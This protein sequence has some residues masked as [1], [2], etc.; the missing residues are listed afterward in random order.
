MTGGTGRHDAGHSQAYDH[1]PSCSLRRQDELRLTHSERPMLAQCNA[2]QL[3]FAGVERRRVVAA[4]D[5][6]MVSS[7]AAAPMSALRI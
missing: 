7:D 3:E 5:G 4:F 1:P 2:E 6:G